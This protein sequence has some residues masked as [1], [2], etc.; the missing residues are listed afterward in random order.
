MNQTCYRSIEITIIYF[1]LLDLQA[2][3]NIDYTFDS[4]FLNL[5]RNINELKIPS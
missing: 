3:G 4:H 1:S 5:A 2:A